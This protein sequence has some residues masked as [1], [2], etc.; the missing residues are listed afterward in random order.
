[1]IRV[2]LPGQPVPSWLERVTQTEGN[3]NDKYT[4]MPTVT[5]GCLCLVAKYRGYYFVWGTLLFGKCAIRVENGCNFT[6][7]GGGKGVKVSSSLRWL[8]VEAKW[9]NAEQKGGAA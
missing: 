5:F 3:E 7:T 6:I 2:F 1:M 4:K 8:F 9:V